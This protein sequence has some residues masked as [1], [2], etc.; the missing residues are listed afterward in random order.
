MLRRLNRRGVSLIE[1]MVAFTLVG[2]GILAL[3]KAFFGV[4]ESIHRS[5][6]ITL[7]TN[8]AQ[9]KMQVLKQKTFY[10][11][12]ITTSTSVRSDI[13]PSITYDNSNYPPETIKEGGITFNRYTYIQ[14]VRE[15][16]GALEIVSPTAGDTGMKLITISLVWNTGSD[17]ATTQLNSVLTNANTVMGISRVQGQV[18]STAGGGVIQDA[19]VT[20]AENVGW[21]DNTSASGVYSIIMSP[22]N[23]NV[24]ATANGYF[25]RM[26]PLALAANASPNIP[27]T[28]TPM[29]SGTIRGYAWIN[30]HLVI[31]QVV[32]R[33]MPGEYEY[34]EIYNPTSSSIT[35]T[36]NSFLLLHKNE[37][38]GASFIQ[39]YPTLIN[40]G[41][42]AYG[43]Y[44]IGNTNPIDFG[45]GVTR[46]VDAYYTNSSYQAPSH[47]IQSGE[48]GG[49]QL[50]YLNPATGTYQLVDTVGVTRGA[51]QPD[52]YY[53]ETTA[54]STTGGFASG[55][56]YVRRTS[57]NTYLINTWGGSYDSANNSSDWVELSSI[58]FRG[59][60]TSYA[61]PPLS[62]TPAAGTIVT[63]NDN[64]S[65]PATAYLTGTPAV[66]MF[67]VPRVATGT[68]TV[69]FATGA[70]FTQI[71]SA[72]MT[73]NTNV[74]IPNSGTS[75]SW[76]LAGYPSILVN[77]P[78]VNGFISG[79]VTNSANAAISPAITVR[80]GGVNATC[81]TSGNY[82]LQVP[83]NTGYIVE[84]NPNNSNPSYVA[85]M[86]NN[87]TVTLGQVTS[88]VDFVLSQGGR[89]TGRITRDGTNPLP[90]VTAIAQ[91]ASSIVMDQ[92]VSDGNG[93]FTLV[94]L[95]T[96]S[97]TVATSL[98][99]A[100]LSTPLSAATTVTSGSTVSVGTFTITGAYG[101]ITGTATAS[102]QVIKTGV[103]VVISTSTMTS[104]PVLST[105]ALSGMTYY[106]GSTMEDGTYSI[107]VRGSTTPY[108]AAG[109]YVSGT[110]GTSAS[111][112]TRTVS[113]IT[114]T[115]GQIST[116][117]NFSW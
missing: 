115:A 49:I 20:I 42:P 117:N 41:I 91:N 81:N 98:D 92:A 13:T 35:L 44:L 75:S 23:Y 52:I 59:S 110:A 30:D 90:G 2:V 26:F 38:T 8:L 57:T 78:A 28:L 6:V 87:V 56:Q 31:S 12:L 86:Q 50:H 94:N 95:T 104:L 32:P 93:Y 47:F 69:F 61:R 18:T 7:A 21:R 27:I 60:N 80:A 1:I 105:A 103:L 5:K 108:I 17:Y 113:N 19:V 3:I 36:A 39:D 65:A 53:R 64:L 102:G 89:I 71:T 66:A 9:E 33:M 111:F 72:T 77:Q 54:L 14:I 11:L 79:R 63:I 24:V 67:Q 112:S 107:A 96:G 82:F 100:E 109:Y 76:T 45:G 116:G 114:V 68:W 70:F 25:D 22:G 101:T 85:Q 15:N 74:W 73:A 29:S 88:N 37:S 16:S 62:G 84:A 55:Q 40:T 43:Y 97:Y 51:T 83:P 106:M 34:I 10:N 46:A 48:A 4:S 58:P 99:D